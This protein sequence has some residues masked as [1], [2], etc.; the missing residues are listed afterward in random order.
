M[1]PGRLP[2]GACADQAGERQ[3]LGARIALAENG[4]G[5][6]GIEEAACV[7]TALQALRGPEQGH[8]DKNGAAP[9]APLIASEDPG[10]SYDQMCPPVLSFS[11]SSALLPMN[12]L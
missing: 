7:V 5:F 11:S 1:K 2:A 4:G 12:R 3:V 9:A 8:S 10:R 6:H